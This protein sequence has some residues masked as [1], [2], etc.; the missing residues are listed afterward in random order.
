MKAV[1][2]LP[3]QEILIVLKLF[4]KTEEEG[5]LLNSFYKAAITQM[6]KPGKGATKQNKTKKKKR[7]KKIIGQYP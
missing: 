1:G 5:S 3:P 2:S 6:P 4:K 7:K